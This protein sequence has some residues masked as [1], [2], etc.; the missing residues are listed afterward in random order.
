MVA[1]LIVI[2]VVTGLVLVGEMVLTTFHPAFKPVECVDQSGRP[3]ARKQVPYE[4]QGTRASW[5]IGLA[6]A[7]FVVGASFA[8]PVADALFGE[9]SPPLPAGECRPSPSPASA[10]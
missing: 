7:G 10:C 6:I 5:Q 4:H 8:T 9:G 1:E 2:A 3:L